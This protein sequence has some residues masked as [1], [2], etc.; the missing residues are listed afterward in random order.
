[1]NDI[2]SSTN[3]K[4]LSENPRLPEK[5]GE[6]GSILILSLW[7]L[8]LLTLMAS[9]IS[10]HATLQMKVVRHHMNQLQGRYLAQAGI[11]WTMN[12]LTKID[13][14]TYQTLSQEWSSNPE[15]FRERKLGHDSFTI[16]Y[17]FLDSQL[18]SQIRFGIMDEERKININTAPKEIL[19]ELPEATEEIV[20]AILDWRDKNTSAE[21]RGVENEY[22]QDLKIPYPSKDGPI[23]QLEE[24]LL[25][26]EVT[27]ELLKKWLSLLT[28]YGDGRV[29]INTASGEIF[30]MIGLDEALSE[31]IIEF[32]QGPDDEIGTED[33]GVFENEGEIARVLFESEPLNAN[34]VSQIINLVSK[35]VLG[36]KS[37]HFTVEAQGISSHSSNPGRSIVAVIEHVEGDEFKIKNWLEK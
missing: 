24:L 23:E 8:A 4:P 11:F 10:F 17:T 7:I 16:S 29:N 5:A 6:K 1:M 36:V 3:P 9:S 22:Y 18:G 26:R 35:G 19:L 15:A 27:P 33:D 20:D 2:Y 34:E 13:K 25:V 21:R 14:E 12:F 30:Q 37:K 31:K 32:R 28:I